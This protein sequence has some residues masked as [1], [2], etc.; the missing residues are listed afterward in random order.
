MDKCTVSRASYFTNGKQTFIEYEEVKDTVQAKRNTAG[1][2][3]LEK[4]LRPCECV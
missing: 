4:N 1:G 2:T 3:Q